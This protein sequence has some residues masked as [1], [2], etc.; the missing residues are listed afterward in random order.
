MQLW[1]S[2]VLPVNVCSG[3]EKI[4]VYLVVL[5]VSL[6]VILS[7]PDLKTSLFKPA[8]WFLV[9]HMF[10]SL[11]IPLSS[12]HVLIMQHMKLVKWNIHII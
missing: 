12:M 2:P 9:V 1:V 10:S 4:G 11:W 6:V 8:P 3:W 5:T 7:S